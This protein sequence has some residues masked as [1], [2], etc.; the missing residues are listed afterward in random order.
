M[1]AK[2][3]SRRKALGS[4][5]GLGTAGLISG[6]ANE[7]TSQP[8]PRKLNLDLNNPEDLAVARQ[9]VIGSIEEEQIHSFLRFHF[10]GQVPGEKARRLMSLNNYIIDYWEPVKRGTY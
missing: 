8:A 5:A 6:C 10:Y 2:K 7:T 3:L 9:K 1:S 4:I